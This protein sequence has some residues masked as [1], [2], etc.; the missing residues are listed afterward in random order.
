MLK[1]RS[2]QFE[3]YLFGRVLVA[4]L[5]IGST[6]IAQFIAQEVLN[7]NPLNAVV[8]F[9]LGYT[10]ISAFI[11]LM[12]GYSGL[13]MGVQFVADLLTLTF[14]VYLTGAYN[15]PLSVLYVLFVVVTAFLV[16]RRAVLHIAS[17]AVIFYGIL[18]LATVFGWIPPYPSEWFP[19]HVG[20]FRPAF[21]SMLYLLIGVMLSAVLITLPLERARMSMQ[22]VQAEQLKVRSLQNMMQFVVTH[23][24]S[25]FFLSDEDGRIL[26]A[27]D[28]GRSLIEKVHIES[29]ENPRLI[30][31]FQVPVSLSELRRRLS[32]TFITSGPD[33]RTYEVRVYSITG[34]GES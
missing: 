14:L 23:M 11:Y 5:V 12:V 13:L 28:R 24:P 20:D 29:D 1:K 6:A 16:S 4:T 33:D 10:L 30:E 3:L 25:P 22:A 15:S 9:M 17:L 19:A 27:N 2:H 18:V 31:I 32:W 8:I 26:F 34:P 7:I 21:F